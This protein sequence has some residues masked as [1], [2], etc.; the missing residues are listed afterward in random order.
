MASRLSPFVR[1]HETH[2]QLVGSGRPVAGLRVRPDAIIV[3]ASR[4]AGNLSHAIALAQAV[5]CR[6]VVLCS[7]EAKA[8]EVME[9]AAAASSRRTVAVDLPDDYDHELLRF[10]SSTLIRDVSPDIFENPNGDLSIKRNL[11]LLLARILGWKRIFFMDDDIRDVTPVDLYATVAMLGRYHSAGMRVISFPDNSVVCHAHRATGATQDIFVSG[12]VLAVNCWKATGFFPDIYNEDWLFFYDD[13]RSGRL[14]WSRRNATQLPYD[15]FDQTRRAERQ[16]F[17][18]V[19]AEG[20]YALLDDGAGPAAATKDYWNSFLMARWK[21]LDDIIKRTDPLTLDVRVKLSSAVQTAMICLMRIQPETCDKFVQ[22][23]RQDLAVWA[24]NLTSVR[25]APSVDA[26]LGRLDLKQADTGGPERTARLA[27]GRK[28]YIRPSTQAFAQASAYLPPGLW[29]A[30]P[31]RARQ[32]RRSIPDLPA[33]LRSDA[34]D[35]VLT[36]EGPPAT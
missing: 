33:P 23:W 20:L 11:G 30:W 34:P 4:P 19:V 13:A 15:P 29:V 35:A 1:Q 3:P 12:S 25:T 27:A 16:E 26:A 6:L 24:G 18:D 8:A 21:F 36:P 17:G 31:E 9:E 28:R 10:T 22:A 5:N 32:S 2:R 7:R 14:G